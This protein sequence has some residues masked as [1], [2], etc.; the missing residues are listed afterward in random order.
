MVI[1]LAPE[2]DKEKAFSCET[3]GTVL[4]V[5]YD[6][7]TWSWNIDSEKVKFILHVLY[8]MLESESVTNGIALSISGKILLVANG[9][10]SLSL[11]FLTKRPAKIAGEAFWLSQNGG[12][13]Q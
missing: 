1:R 9:G 12:S 2:T 11:T 6:T 4:G 7:V 5:K 8:D 10:R 13:C 3:A